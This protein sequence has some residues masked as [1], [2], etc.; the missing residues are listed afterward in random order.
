[1]RK[2]STKK[3]DTKIY[4]WFYMAVIVCYKIKH[5]GFYFQMHSTSLYNLSLSIS[6]KRKIRIPYRPYLFFGGGMSHEPDIFFI[7]QNDILT[8]LLCMGIHV[9]LI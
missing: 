9:L 4:I 5:G 1:M 6:K 7:W 2:F 8:K 3:V